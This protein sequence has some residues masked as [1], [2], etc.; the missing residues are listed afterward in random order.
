MRQEFS[1]R[2]KVNERIEISVFYLPESSHD[3]VC[4]D[5]KTISTGPMG[6][7]SFHVQLPRPVVSELIEVLSTLENKYPL[8]EE[9]VNE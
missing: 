9:V 2:I 1:E 3:V 6:H 8:K 4:V 7:I 5:F